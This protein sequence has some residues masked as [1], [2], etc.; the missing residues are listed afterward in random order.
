[1]PLLISCFPFALAQTK[2]KT[3]AFVNVTP[4]PAALGKPLLVNS[5][6]VPQPPMV[7]GTSMGQIRNG[8]FYDFTK[9]DGT[10]ATVGPRPSDSGG[11]GTDWF[12]YTPDQ[13]GTWKLKF[14]WAGDTLFEGVTSPELTFTVQKDV[15]KQSWSET[16]LPDSYWTRPIS[17][18]NRR[19]VRFGRLL[20]AIYRTRHPML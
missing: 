16:P 7:P 14:R 12:E 13:V 19:M 6:V 5:W 2:T 11:S 9:P 10:T 8:Y 15:V 4:Q 20:V 3:F 17:V 1:M 18:V